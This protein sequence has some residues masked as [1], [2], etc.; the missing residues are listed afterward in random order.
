M[1]R[2]VN[3]CAYPEETLP[4]STMKSMAITLP[5]FHTIV[6]EQGQSLFIAL[7]F[8]LSCYSGLVRQVAIYGQLVLYAMVIVQQIEFIRGTIQASPGGIGWTTK[9]SKRVSWYHSEKPE[10]E[11]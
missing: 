10:T 9:S 11:S 5:A 3:Y 2:S 4:K 8:V 6:S 1:L 7:I